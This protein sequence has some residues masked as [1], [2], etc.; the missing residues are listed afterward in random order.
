MSEGVYYGGG[1]IFLDKVGGN[2]VIFLE[3]ILIFR[4]LKF[5]SVGIKGE[6]NDLR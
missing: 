2:L 3:E 4:F 5:F 6:R 1:F